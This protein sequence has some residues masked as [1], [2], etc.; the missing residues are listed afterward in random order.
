MIQNKHVIA[1]DN[2]KGRAI[3]EEVALAWRKE[4]IPL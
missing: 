1:Q 2:C 4:G 3:E